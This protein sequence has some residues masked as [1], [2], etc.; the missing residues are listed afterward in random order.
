M[1]KET[2]FFFIDFRK[3]P[4]FSLTSPL[5]QLREKSSRPV[6]TMCGEPCP[7]P[8]STAKSTVLETGSYLVIS[9]RLGCVTGSKF[10]LPGA[11]NFATFIF[12]IEMFNVKIFLN[13]STASN[14]QTSQNVV[15]RSVHFATQA[16]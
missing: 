16:K 15:S 9:R 3:S 13:S 4:R 6:F 7:L 2:L 1:G 11:L 14:W 12:F 8:N 5:S 10:F